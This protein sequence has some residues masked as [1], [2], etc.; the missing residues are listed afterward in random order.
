MCKFNPISLRELITQYNPNK[1]LI[2]FKFFLAI[3]MYMYVLP[4]SAQITAQYIKNYPENSV[5]VSHIFVSSY[6]K[7]LFLFISISVIH[8]MTLRIEYENNLLWK[9]GVVLFLSPSALYIYLVV[10][11]STRCSLVGRR[12]NF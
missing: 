8:G 2:K 3:Y 1:L 5:S 6:F 7:L 10:L 4:W 11:V 9:F 12:M